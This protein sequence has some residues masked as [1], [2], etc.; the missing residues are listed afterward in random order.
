MVG[1]RLEKGEGIA[2]WVVENDE[3]IIVQDVKKDPRFFS[4]V[5]RQIGFETSAI[6][7]VPIRVHDEVIGVLEALNPHRGEF[8]PAILEILMGIAGMAGTAIQH[9]RLF[10]ETQAARKRFTGLFEDSIDPIL[11]SDLEGRLT[12]AN[13]S[14]QNYLGRDAASLENVRVEDL[15][16]IPS[17][18]KIPTFDQMQAGDSRSYVAKLLHLDGS[19]L[20]V[21]VYVKRMDVE[22]QPVLQWIMRDMSE[23]QAL[24]QL[25]A[26]LTSMIFHDLRSPLGN[27]IS[28]LEV[29]K[30]SVEEEDELLSPV[31]SVAQR[32][33]RRL[34]RLIDSLLD[35][36]LLE[37]GKAVLYKTVVSLPPLVQEAVEEVLPTAEAKGHDLSID[38]GD[39]LPKVDIDVDMIRRV[40]IN[41]VE[42]AVK[43]TPS[44]GKIVITV[45]DLGD[46]VQLGVN[47]TG[48]GIDPKDQARIF[49]KFARVERKGR[50]KGLG[51]GLAFCRLAV[52]ARGGEIW[53]ES[54]ADQGSTFF[55][56]L[57]V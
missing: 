34:S 7:C 36:S 3:P 19:E 32:S 53:V 20:P 24:D 52:E 33:S 49:D 51:L 28:S 38:E 14:A 37:E 40:I 47:D 31:I 11:I 50:S 16:V 21:E 54:E 44:G 9:A 27:I 56:S 43:Y 1:I 41:L 22:D 6:A 2:G 48:S 23:R 25:R 17:R 46:K 15:H 55:F 39:E 5:D 18:E 8:E 26:D 12:E 13:V 4:E 42:N 57:P 29:M 35:I 10:A 45:E 30:S